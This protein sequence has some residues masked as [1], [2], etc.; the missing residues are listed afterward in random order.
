M[1]S[2]RLQSQ[3]EEKKTQTAQ[4]N[5]FQGK[6]RT[7]VFALPPR[8]E[9]SRIVDEVERRL[10]L[11]RGV[12]MQVEDNLRRAEKLRQATLHTIFSNGFTHG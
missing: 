7:L 5:I 8:S 12:E 10:S 4:A 2:P 1:Q 3:I 11:I 9:Q 6:I